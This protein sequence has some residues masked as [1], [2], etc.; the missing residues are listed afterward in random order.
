MIHTMKK[1]PSVQA[2][3]STRHNGVSHKPFES[4]NLGFHVGDDEKNVKKNHEMIRSVFGT[5]SQLYHMDQVH[6]KRVCEIGKREDIPSCDALMTDQ[7]DKILMVMVADCVPL[8]FFDTK[9]HSIAAIH[10]GRAGAFENIVLQTFQ[11]M[12]SSYGTSADELVVSMGPHIRSCC[13]EVGEEIFQA[14]QELDLQ[15]FIEIRHEKY[16]LDMLGIIKQQLKDIGVKDSNIEEK[17]TCTA[18]DT[19]NFFSYRKEGKTGRFC[20]VIMLK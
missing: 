14:A 18:C 1:L 9:H 19:S 11:T 15:S 6:S 16:F 20:G 3:F 2:F 17:A 13:Y 7:N 10:A 4:L 12:Q 5:N 8:L